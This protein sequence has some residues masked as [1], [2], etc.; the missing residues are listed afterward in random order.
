MILFVRITIKRNEAIIKCVCV[1][2]M[3]QSVHSSAAASI[4]TA[5]SLL[6]FHPN[7]TDSTLQTSH[8]HASN[9]D[10]NH[11]PPTSTLDQL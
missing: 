9:R 7:L 5:K 4:K 10:L 8:T 2:S 11:A 6:K 1:W 3:S